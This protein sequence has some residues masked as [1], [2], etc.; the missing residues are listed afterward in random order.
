MFEALKAL[1]IQ[2]AN[3]EHLREQKRQFLSRVLSEYTKCIFAPTHAG[4]HQETLERAESEV[5]DPAA[6]PDYAKDLFNDDLQTCYFEALLSP[7][8]EPPENHP[9][10][11][12]HHLQSLW[13]Y[14]A[15]LIPDMLE[16]PPSV[17]SRIDF[18]MTRAVTRA[19][20]YITQFHDK[21]PDRDK[22]MDQ[23]IWK[24]A[25]KAAN[26]PLVVAEYNAMGRHISLHRDAQIVSK[27][28]KEKGINVGPETVKNYLKEHERG[29][30]VLEL[31]RLF[32]E[33]SEEG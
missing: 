23:N 6:D 2:E 30:R 8:Y 28:L 11:L 17:A 32:S 20:E 25:Q 1:L 10:K 21:G 12:L 3:V 26:M 16:V 24:K 14:Y 27:R 15:D 13:L 7:D 22:I 9:L 19:V 33:V 31:P 29:I 18:A 5:T 4:R